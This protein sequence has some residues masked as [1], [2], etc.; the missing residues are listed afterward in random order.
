MS[1]KVTIKIRDSDGSGADVTGTVES[2]LAWDLADRLTKGAVE[3]LE[4]RSKLTL[5]GT[6]LAE[7]PPKEARP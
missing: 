1:A 3:Y 4:I 6:P 7:H 2:K 5:D